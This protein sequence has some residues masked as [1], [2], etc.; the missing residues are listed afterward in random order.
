M[1]HCGRIQK[2]CSFLSHFRKNAKI[3]FDL[4]FQTGTK[5]KQA[6]EFSQGTA[7]KKEQTHLKTYKRYKDE[8]AFY[9]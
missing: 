1:R 7:D 2:K 3:A 6:C 5:K 9:L 8:C 4:I